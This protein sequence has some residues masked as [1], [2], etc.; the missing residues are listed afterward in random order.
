ML[1]CQREV[2]ADIRQRAVVFHVLPRPGWEHEVF[3]HGQRTQAGEQ[4]DVVEAEPALGAELLRVDEAVERR[5]LGLQVGDKLRSHREVLVVVGRLG[6]GVVADEGVARVLRRE[7]GEV[8]TRYTGTREASDERRVIGE[9]GGE[10]LPSARRAERAR[11]AVARV[12]VHRRADVERFGDRGAGGALRREDRHHLL[13]HQRRGRGDVVVQQPY[14]LMLHVLH[15]ETVTHAH[16]V[17]TVVVLV[18]PR[19]WRENDLRR[20]RGRER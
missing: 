14:Q 13:A 18:Q 6:Q 1:R 12:R 19:Q 7:L 16:A 10:V 3:H 8:R 11:G 5:Q 20:F 17:R 4:V 9:Q 2:I 15:A